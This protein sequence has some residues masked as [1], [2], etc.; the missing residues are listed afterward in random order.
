MRMETELLALHE[1]GERA[2]RERPAPAAVVSWLC[3]EGPGRLLPFSRDLSPGEWR[4]L[5]LA[6]KEHVIGANIRRCLEASGGAAGPL[7]LC[8]G[9]AADDELVAA[10]SDALL[11]AGISVSRANVAG[12]CGSRYAVALGAALSVASD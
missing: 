6:L 11:D 3:A 5:R 8:G 2:F 9:G 10:V 12:C 4:A 1:S 7:L